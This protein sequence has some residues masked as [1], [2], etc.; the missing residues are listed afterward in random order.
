MFLL[1]GCGTVFLLWVG[2]F[3]LLF[4]QMRAFA[5]LN[6]TELPQFSTHPIEGDDERFLGTVR[7]TWVVQSRE[8]PDSIF[9]Q[10]A[11]L[12]GVDESVEGVVTFYTFT[13]PEFSLVN[14]QRNQQAAVIAK[15]QAIALPISV[16]NRV[17][18]GDGICFIKL[19]DELVE[20]ME[21]GADGLTRTL[22]AK[23]KAGEAGG[24]ASGEGL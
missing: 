20:V 8:E 16:D 14:P 22:Y 13:I 5:K 17:Y 4:P 1:I 6:E 24:E 19:T 12:T 15:A 18:A 11:A 3:V 2:W 23:P 21:D 9:A 7:Q 10:I